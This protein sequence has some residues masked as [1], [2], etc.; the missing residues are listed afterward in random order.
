MTDSRFDNVIPLERL[1]RL[2]VG[3]VLIAVIFYPS[4]TAFWLALLAVY[5]VMTAIMAWD[6]LYA[7]MEQAKV[8][9]PFNKEMEAQV[10]V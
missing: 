7:L 10:S 2:A 4:V 6:P 8:Q 5:P 1:I 9:M 3:G